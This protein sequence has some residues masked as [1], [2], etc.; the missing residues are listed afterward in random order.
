MKLVEKLSGCMYVLVGL[1]RLH[2]T[3]KKNELSD[4]AFSILVVAL[5]IISMFIHSAPV[6]AAL[7]ATFF[8]GIQIISIMK[9]YEKNNRKQREALLWIVMINMLG[10]LFY[11]LLSSY[12][13]KN[14][15]IAERFLS[16]PPM[17]S[18]D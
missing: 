2:G 10:V 16:D 13:K 8:L 11:V 14:P 6:V 3:E 7:P 4:R 18:S 17:D 9:E 12:E 1:V 5:A 15:Y